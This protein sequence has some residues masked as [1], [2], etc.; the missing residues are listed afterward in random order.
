MINLRLA[1][2]TT[3]MVA[4]VYVSV[5]KKTTINMIYDGRWLDDLS[6]R[7]VKDVKTLNVVDAPHHFADVLVGNDLFFD[8]FVDEM[9]NSSVSSVVTNDI[10]MQ[11]YAG[12]TF[13]TV[14]NRHSNEKKDAKLAVLITSK[15]L[16]ASVYAYGH[17]DVIDTSTKRREEMESVAICL[18][19]K[20]SNYKCLNSR[21]N[22]NILAP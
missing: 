17:T 15:D 8:I 20:Y 3:I 9:S 22:R 1:A 14:K 18:I 19:H 12:S 16:I 5:R 7:P 11:A 6:R 10:K 13:N 21:Y 2:A 4:N